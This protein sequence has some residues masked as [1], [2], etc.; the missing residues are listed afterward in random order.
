MRAMKDSGIKWIGEIPE[1]W[2]VKRIKSVFDRRNE[3][4]NPILSKERLSLSIDVGITKYSDKTTNLDRFKEDF[5][6]YQLAYPND[7]VLNSMNMIVGAVGKSEFFGCVSPVYY[8]ITT[9][10]GNYASFYAYLLNTLSIREVYHSLGRGIYAIERGEGRVNTCRL[11]VPYYD[12]SSIL[13]PVPPLSE[14]QRIATYLDTKCGEIDQLIGIQEKF[15]EELKAYKQSVITEAVTKGLN[16]NATLKDSGVEWIGEIPEEWEVCRIKNYF[17]INSGTTPQSDKTEYWGEDYYWVTPADFKTEDKYIAKGKRSLS[18]LGFESC[19]LTIYPK[20]SLIF[21]KRAPIGQIVIA[22]N[23]LCVNQGCF[24]CTPLRATNS[25]YFYFLLSIY[26]TQFELYGSGTTF[27]E[28]S[29]ISFKNFKIACPKDLSEQQSI[30]TYLD[31]KCSQIDSLI[32]LKQSKIEE[33]KSFK[34]S[35][36]YEYVTGKKT[37]PENV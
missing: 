12:F 31:N 27:K 3:V 1:E 34:K 37:V 35:L 30:A 19:S 33:L 11:K 13:I 9:K 23:E 7:I 21:S 18:K 8:V 24:G 4:N 29:A 10:D 26:K 22:S 17:S 32:T 28:I 36:I 2:E 25:S 16:P 5:T 14:Q 6:K 20:G 15:I